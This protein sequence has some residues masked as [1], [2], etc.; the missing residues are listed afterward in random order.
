MFEKRCFKCGLVKPLEEFYKHERMA[1]GHLNK[2]K[3]CNKKDVRQNYANKRAQY[4]DYDRRRNKTEARKRQQRESAK[5]QRQIHP[6]KFAMRGVFWNAI[7]SGKI[8]R[9]PCVKCGN[10]KSEGHHHDYSKPLDVIW[11]CFVCHRLE[12]GEKPKG[13]F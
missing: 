9:M 12:H 10:P 7:V 13:T 2:C 5:L 11:M 1:D 6:E 8:K 3:T 4:Q